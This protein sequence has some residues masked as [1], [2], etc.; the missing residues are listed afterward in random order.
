MAGAYARASANGTLPANARQIMYAARPKIQA[1]TG[2]ALDDQYF[3]QTLLPDYVNEHEVD[4]DVVYDDR[5][6]FREPHGTGLLGLGTLNVRD[7]LGRLDDGAGLEEDDFQ[8]TEKLFSI[9]GPKHRFGAILF[10][11]KEGFMS[12]FD[13]VQLAERFDIAIMSTKGVSVTAARYLVDELCGLYDIPLLVL[14]DFD[15]S[16][17]TIL[18]TL[19]R[20]TRR[21]SFCNDIK[22]IDLGLRLGDIGGL[23]TETVHHHGD[24]HAI[25]SNLRENGSTENEINFLMGHRVEL[26]A[27]TSPQLVGF[28]ERK[29]AAAGITKVV[30]ETSI[31]EQAYRRA[32]T[33]VRLSQRL[34]ELRADVGREVAATDIPD[35]LSNQVRT[36]LAA[37]PELPW[38][39]AVRR[40][41]GA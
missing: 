35:D 11:E 37:H 29:L 23:E 6:H 13:A 17:F 31:L 30:P 2:K 18:G 32:Q 28:I 41:V 19:Q 8:L 4:W 25:E 34:D 21:Y 36:I 9:R 33:H 7:Y 20:D 39:E 3:T 22:V 12:L 5:G 40:I 10:I 38:D 26:N 14:H 27:M 16:G 24:E 15:K 1:V